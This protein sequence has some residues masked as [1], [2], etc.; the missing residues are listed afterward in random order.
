MRAVNSDDLYLAC[1]L[2][3]GILAA[4]YFQ[5]V[6][7]KITANDGMLTFGMVCQSFRT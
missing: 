4:R 7:L 5:D 3:K 6:E 1:L 2:P